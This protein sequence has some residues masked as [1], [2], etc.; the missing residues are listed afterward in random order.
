MTQ[1]S[2]PASKPTEN[3]EQRAYDVVL[4]WR[5]TVEN[6]VAVVIAYDEQEAVKI[7]LE[8]WSHWFE[9]VSVGISTQCEIIP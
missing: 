2:E 3:R 5:H 4:N 7:A 8:A 1:A 9:V 6:E